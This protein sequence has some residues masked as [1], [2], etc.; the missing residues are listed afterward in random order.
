M[1][2][3]KVSMVKILSEHVLTITEILAQYKEIPSNNC[4]K[5]LQRNFT[6]LIL[7]IH[8]FVNF[9]TL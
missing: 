5:V 8:Q 7:C 2:S 9:L 1:C 3:V 4:Q 6:V